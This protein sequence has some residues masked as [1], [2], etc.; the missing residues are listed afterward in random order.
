MSTPAYVEIVRSVGDAKP[1]KLEFGVSLVG[2]A[3]TMSV[4]S[5]GLSIVGVAQ[6]A[7]VFQFACD[8]AITA[9]AGVHPYFVVASGGPETPYTIT[10]GA[11]V[12][13][14]QQPVDGITW[15]DVINLPA[16][17]LVTIPP[18]TQS[19]ILT[20][21]NGEGINPEAFGENVNLAR[22]YLAAH[23]ASGSGSAAR[24]ATGPVVSQSVGGI[25]RSYAAMASS[26]GL[27]SSGYGKLLKGMIQRSEYCRVPLVL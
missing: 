9:A 3:L 6:S 11:W 19:K 26:D 8:P 25:S 27:E 15:D 22:V 10:V 20:Y 5:L 16:A 17:Q 24:G 13:L 7:T 23:L 12:T 1:A 18:I 4:P 21:V 2:F 14:P